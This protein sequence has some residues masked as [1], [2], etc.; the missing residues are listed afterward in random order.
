M[1][2]RP[3]KSREGWGLFVTGL[4][5]EAGDFGDF[6]GGPPFHLALALDELSEFRT[7][8]TGHWTS[9]NIDQHP[10]VPG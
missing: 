3:A 2:E 10:D 1:A 9:F 4:P 5:N 6:L 8:K 7:T